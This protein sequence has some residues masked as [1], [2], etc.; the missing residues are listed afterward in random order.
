MKLVFHILLLTSFLFPQSPERTIEVKGTGS[1]KTMPDLG[2]VTMEASVVHEQFADAVKGLNAKS[3]KLTAQLQMIGFKKED[4]K[5]TD[6]SVS[7]KI[8]WENNSN[9]EKGYIA[10]QNISVEFPNTKEKIGAIIT[11]FMGS[12]NDVRFSFNFTLSGAKEKQVQDELLK[13]T[14]NDARAR[15]EV[16]TAAAKQT[17]GNVKHISYGG[18]L[19]RPIYQPMM[20]KG[21][22]S[23]NERS[24]G[25]DVK[26][27]S[28][29]DEVTIV[30][31]LK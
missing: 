25:F 1:Y 3:E 17:I 18:M 27:I 9:V 29:T 31:E 24:A 7:K 30:W 22:A 19:Q 26:E 10:R 21:V 23:D 28:F 13:R 6:F 11:S 15:A 16:I 4:I 12:E 5:T 2:V 20:M 8:V 14:V